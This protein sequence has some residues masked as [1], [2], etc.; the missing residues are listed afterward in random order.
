MINSSLG[1]LNASLIPAPQ[2]APSVE[3][4]SCVLR[5]LDASARICPSIMEKFYETSIV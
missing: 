5:V 4:A 1:R 3:Q 2:A